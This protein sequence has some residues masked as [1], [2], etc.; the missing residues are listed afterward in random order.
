MEE[1]EEK[2]EEEEEI[3]KE[4]GAEH[5]TLTPRFQYGNVHELI[6]NDSFHFVTDKRGVKVQ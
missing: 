5:N 2:E 4:R 6:E 1:E 3:P